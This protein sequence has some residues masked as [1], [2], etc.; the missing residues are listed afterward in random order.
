M[1]NYKFKTGG[2]M[3]LLTYIGECRLWFAVSSIFSIIISLI[4]LGWCYIIKKLLD[5]AQTYN[6]K[7]LLFF[8]SLAA[9]FFVL[10]AFVEMVLKYSTVKFQET[11]IYNIRNEFVS[12]ILNLPIKYMESQKNGDIQ[13]RYINDLNNLKAFFS[14]TVFDIIKQP[15]MFIF[16]LCYMLYLSW[17]LTL[18]CLVISPIFIFISVKITKPIYGYTK[19]RN[20]ALSFENSLV[21]N[22][23]GGIAA[24]KAFLLENLMHAKYTAAADKTLSKE[25]KLTKINSLIQPLSFGMRVIPTLLSLGFGNYLLLNNA[26]TIGS[27]LAIVQLQNYVL[28]P[29]MVIPGILSSINS[30]KASLTRIEEILNEPE[31]RTEGHILAKP[32]LTEAVLIKNL[33]FAY[34]NGA[35]VLNNLSIQINNNELI[36]LVGKSGCGKST[37]L[38]LISGI[39]IPQKGTVKI[40]GHS[41]EDWNIK[42]IRNLISIVSQDAYIYPDSIYKNI[43]YG[44]MN[45]SEEDVIN[46]AKA[47]NIHDFIISLPNGYNTIVDEHA[48]MLSGGQ[49][50][51]ICIARAI[52]K[53][54]P[55]ILFDEP[56]SA[57]DAENEFLINEAIKNLAN[58]HTVIIVAHRLSTIKNVSKILVMDS[59]EIQAAGTH[60]ELINHCEIYKSLFYK[61][62]CV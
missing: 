46:S 2:F 11:I 47:A 8:I 19:E 31:E 40:F 30:S 62:Y 6:Y 23:L 45:S 42:N 54:S 20:E 12:H 49:K 50:Q 15:L 17:K 9:L 41:L 26:I 28:G 16:S 51:R 27:I 25:L 56:T 18:F 5:S 3:H 52:L 35:N 36:A 24:L 34:E 14:S 38:K 22:N 21:A 4:T 1:I 44:N 32:H 43:L 29:V 10:E 48:L 60:E 61:Q 53:D 58:K 7:S 57:L 33:T 13:S 39:Y 37:L 59:G 55:I